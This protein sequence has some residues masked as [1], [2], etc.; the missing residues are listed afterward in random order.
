MSG[1]ADGAPREGE[2][3]RHDECYACPIGGFFLTLQGSQPDATEHLL[4]AAH[5]M[6]EVARAVIDAA[7]E[8]IESRREAAARR[9]GE[10][11]VRRIDIG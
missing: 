1:A 3:E 4:N 10:G 11:R 7:D 2:A 8:V 5:E 9:V 6:I